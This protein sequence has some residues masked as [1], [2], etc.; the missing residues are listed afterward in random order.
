MTHRFLTSVVPSAQSALRSL[1]LAGGLAG[2]LALS[3]LSPAAAMD[4]QK[5]VS[6]GGIEAWLVEDHSIPVISMGI[7]FKGGSALDPDGK[8]GLATMVAGLLDEGSADLDSQTFRSRLEQKAIDLSFHADQDAFTGSLRTL[9]ENRD[10]AFGLFRDALTKP[11]FD[12]EPVD[13]I[14]NQILTALAFKKDD[15]QEL[16]SEAW[17]KS[18]FPGHPYSRPEEGTEASI[19]AIT[20]DDLRSFTALQL[21]RNQLKVGVAGDITPQQLGALLDDT[22]GTLPTAA[23]ALPAVPD[24]TPKTGIVTVIKRDIPQSVAAF[25]TPGLPR[26]D[27]DFFAA[28]VVNYILGG[29]GFSSRLMNEVRE[30]RGLAYSV[31][32][33]LYPLDHAALSLGG[34]ATNNARMKES[35]DL[36]RKEMARMAKEG[37]TQKELDD[38]KTY[39]VG[40]YPLRFTSTMAMASTLVALQLQGYPIEHLTKRNDYIKAV[41]LADAKRAASRLYNPDALTI[42][43]VGNPEGIDSSKP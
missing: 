29:G 13:R 37:P 12:D 31:Y 43:I 4:A 20:R 22:F 25:G 18:A 11:R 9:S 6:P 40:A 34:V 10:E 33:Y 23:S 42:A 38:A 21:V 2:L 27:P 36:I 24:V 32:N 8:E 5:V 17:S 1:G 26:Q 7:A 35:L 30:K 3:A 41:T 28:Y 19:K 16:A 14:R 15:P 39:L